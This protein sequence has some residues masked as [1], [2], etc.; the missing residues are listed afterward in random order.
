MTDVVALWLVEGPLTEDSPL[1][2]TEGRLIDGKSLQLIES[3]SK[4][5]CEGLSDRVDTP[6]C[7]IAV[8]GLSLKLLRKTGGGLPNGPRGGSLKIWES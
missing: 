3:P 7:Q 8:L 2:A 4:I 5:L 6:R 1:E